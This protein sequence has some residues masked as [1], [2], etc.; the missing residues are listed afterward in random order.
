M[1]G[2]VITDLSGF[3]QSPGDIAIQSDGKILAAGSSRPNGSSASLGN[4]ELV[5]YNADGSLDT[6]FGVGGKVTTAFG[7]WRD[8]VW[9]LS[10]QPDGKIVAGGDTDSVEYAASGFALARYNRD[11]LLDTSFGIGGK[12]KTE[13]P[14]G[15]DA[16]NLR[17]LEIQSDGKVVAVGTGGI[18][19]WY[20]SAFELARYNTTGLLLV[21]DINFDQTRV[22]AGGSWSATLSG[23]NLTNQTY[24]DVRFRSP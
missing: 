23:T 20:F 24:F 21:S 18:Q 15:R 12:V 17:S 13:A 4:F 5:R 19:N 22:G 7:P 16:Y 10:L 6:M 3:A 14:P 1:G 2:K 11:G 8:S 9:A